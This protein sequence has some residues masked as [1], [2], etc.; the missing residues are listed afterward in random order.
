MLST[1]TVE[2]SNWVYS[3]SAIDPTPKELVGGKGAGLAEM[4]AL[5]VPV[6]P[7]FTISTDACTAYV[8]GGDG[9]P[10]GLMQQV[11]ASIRELESTTG[12]RFG[13][14]QDPLLVSVRSG[15][16]VSMP[17]MM[18]TV[19]NL[20]IN[21]QVAEAIAYRTGSPRFARDLHR[22][23]I[24][25]YG[26]VVLGVESAGFEQVL[27]EE[28]R[29]AG[30]SR[31]A[32][33]DVDRLDHL[34]A[35]FEA[36]IA[37]ATLKSVP[38]DP[39]QQLEHAI[40]AVF[41][42]WNNRRAAQYR[43]FHGISH[44]LGTAVNIVAMV[45][46][47]VDDESCTGVVF[48]RDPASGKKQVYGEY[49][50]NAQGEDVVT[51][52]STPRDL[53]ALAVEMPRVYRRILDVTCRLEHHYRDAQDIE[54]TVEQGELYI[55]QIRSAQRTARAA[56]K[57]A[58]DM[59]NEG[60]ITQDEALLRI[61]ADQID[62][63]LL[64]TI[65]EPERANARA[66]GRLVAIGLG[67]SPGGA[68]GVAAFDAY[69][70]EELGGRGVDVIL[71]RPETTPDD[72]NGMLAAKGILT[73]RGGTT[74]H[75]A[76]VA[77]GLGK[78][79]VTGAEELEVNADEGYLRGGG[80]VVRAGEKLTLDG[81][82]GEVF[83]GAIP[84][85]MRETSPGGGLSRL[86]EWA[87]A[88]RKLGVW[89]NA[90]N[91]RDAQVALDLGAEGVGLCRTE[92][93]FFG[94]ERLRFVRQMIL[95]AHSLRQA[96]DDLELIGR[97]HEAITRLEE[98]QEHDFIEI[99]NVMDGRP[100]VIRLL[101][102]PLHEFLPGHDDLLEQVVELRTR[103]NDPTTL[104]EKQ[105]L[106]A[107]VDE[108]RETNPMLGLRGC[109]LGLKFPEIYG[110]Q[111][112]APTRAAS[113]VK[114]GGTPVRPEIM[115]PLVGHG[116]EMARL[117]E[118][119][120]TTIHRCLD[121][122]DTELEYKIGAMIELPRAALTANEIAESAEFFSFGTNDLTQTVFGLSRDDAEAKFLR[123][124]IEDGILP[125]DPFKVLDRRGVGQLMRTA[126]MLG[127]HTRPDIK[128]GI[129]GEHGGDP[130]S[131]EFCHLEGLDYVSCSPY[132]LPVARLAAAHA[133]IRATRPPAC[134]AQT[135]SQDALTRN[136]RSA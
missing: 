72:V 53:S 38:R 30:V 107:V 19:L 8:A 5:G 56:V 31:S 126:A 27:Q 40:G 11:A 136:G 52:T 119:L 39:W 122:A 124:Y 93:M 80:I 109:R 36:L 79:C 91:A 76:V 77:R 21:R 68:T 64:P 57:I 134:P 16:V 71:V 74:S 104:A 98:F 51:G 103:G 6:P 60:L 41:D 95:S 125:E 102:P 14:A 100:V 123:D 61:G 18:D 7:G 82:T 83:E 117:R 54:F 26:S 87:D 129:C 24:Q 9:L 106:L 55:L 12:K 34:V 120:E 101:D 89:A 112:R 127:R 84:L 10:E 45:Y 86:L 90:D 67:A 94:S 81:T 1:T 33:L 108:L 132:R 50:K 13:D 96:P 47:N 20:G 121:E 35:A 88:R 58:V 37:D 22:R 65:D 59:A 17:G 46:G 44:E 133:A 66:E 111:V 3:F 75:A 128:L 105:R 48:T 116:Q 15:A 110:M 42:S 130:S 73:G 62:Q 69:T 63:L 118:S 92:H 70:A 4:T 29:L 78:P 25:M 115:I 97:L 113:R 2:Q 114:A 43:N 49:L 32:D 131:I 135:S 99:F 28:Q 85:A 23:F